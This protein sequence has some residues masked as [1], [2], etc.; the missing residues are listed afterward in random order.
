MVPPEGIPDGGKTIK[1]KPQKR[2][3]KFPLVQ[4]TCDLFYCLG[5]GEGE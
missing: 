3:L 1:R 5:G 2:L 4:C